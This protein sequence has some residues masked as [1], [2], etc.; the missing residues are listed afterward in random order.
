MSEVV[1]V[2]YG[3]GN[4]RSVRAALHHLGASSIVSSDPALI[5]DGKFVVLPGVG[6]ARSAMTHLN[7]TGA[8]QAL[9]NRF[10]NGRPILGICLGMQLALE[11]S[12]EDGGVDGL[13]LLAGRVVLMHAARVPRL[14]WANVEPWGESYYFAHSYAVESPASVATSEGVIVAVEDGSFFGVQFHPEKSANA[15]LTFLKQCLSLA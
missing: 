11:T 10:A 15:G 13:G 4:T 2:D 6:S 3:A 8:A 12:E 9:R 7:A 1:V 5:S 14:G